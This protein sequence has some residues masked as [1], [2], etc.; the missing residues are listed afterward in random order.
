MARVWSAIRSVGAGARELEPAGVADERD[1]EGGRHLFV[2]GNVPQ[3]DELGC[4]LAGGGGLGDDELV[5]GPVLL[6]EVMIEHELWD[7]PVGDA[8]LQAGQLRPGA[9]V[10]DEEAVEAGEERVQG[11]GFR[12]H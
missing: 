3:L 2:N 10:G 7:I 8:F 11:S 4:D 5:I 6:R 12:V 9:G 1:I